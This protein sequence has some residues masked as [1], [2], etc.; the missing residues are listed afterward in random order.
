PMQ[1]VSITSRREFLRRSGAALLTGFGAGAARAEKPAEVLTVDDWIKKRAA[2]APLA[3]RFR[4]STA[5]ECRKWQDGFSAK[6]R[7]LLG[8]FAPP[9]KWQ[10]VTERTVDLED[11]RRE[12]LV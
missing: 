1:Q 4:G 3:M 9:Q 5:A 12:E 7:T 11:H 8:D 2:D 10:T 6:L